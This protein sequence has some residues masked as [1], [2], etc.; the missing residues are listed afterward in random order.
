M[1]FGCIGKMFVVEYVG[2]IS[3][4]LVLVKV[5][6]GGMLLGVIV[7][8]WELYEKWLIV[9]YGFIFGGNLVLCVVVLVNILII[10]EEKFVEC[11]EKVGVDIV[12][13]F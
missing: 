3:D 2:V 9:G 12:K 4:I 7:V 11:S 8:S 13:C 1:G 10:E 5:F 6:F